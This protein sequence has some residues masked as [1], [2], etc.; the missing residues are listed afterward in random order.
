[1][2]WSRL[3]VRCGLVGVFSLE[4]TASASAQVVILHS[5]TG[6]TGDGSTPFASL[7]Q[8]GSTLY[9]MT[10][11]GGSANLGTTFRLGTDG[12]GFGVLHSF[13]GGA[14]DGR[15]PFGSL[16]Q[17]GSTLYGMTSRGGG[18]DGGTV[19]RGGTDGSG[20]SVMRSFTGASNDGFGPYGS[21]V[22]SSSTLFGM[23]PYGGSN[24]GTIFKIGNDGSNY[25]L[26]HAFA[27]G[28]G[29]GQSP[30]YASL[31]QSGSNLYGMTAFGGTANLGTIFRMAMDGTGYAVLHSFAGGAADGQKPYGSLILSGSTLYGMTDAGSTNSGAIFKIETDGTGITQLHTFAGGP[32]DGS[33]PRG[34]LILSGST[35]YGMTPAGGADNLGSIFQ[36]ATDGTGYAMIHSFAGGP[37]D[38]AN[39]QGD[40]I[41]SGSTLYGMTE[42][43]GSNDQGTVFSFTPVPEPSS[44]L[45]TA[46]ATPLALLA[47]RRRMRRL[48]A[49]RHADKL[50]R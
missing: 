27:G 35:L 41:L 47:R 42:N 23:T 15:L 46:A 29:D 28:P 10:V 44:L 50:A 30:L 3:F 6:G 11:F 20:F 38:G 26:L 1:M 16:V 48:L 36:L 34:G 45:L 12:S 8:S 43:G 19:F 21:L 33:T 25:G 31:A 14:G 4:L 37:D 9:G 49:S 7:T 5:F 24:G 13:V 32:G 18:A 40:L 22:V 2:H 39:P 17:S